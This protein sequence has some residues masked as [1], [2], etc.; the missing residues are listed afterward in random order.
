MNDDKVIIFGKNP[1]FEYIEKKPGRITK[2]FIKEDASS[3]LFKDIKARLHSTD[4]QLSAVPLAKLN[5]IA[6]KNAHHQGLIAEISPVPYLILEDWLEQINDK[7][8]IFLVIVDSIQDPHN[9]GAIIRTAVASG[10]TALMMGTRD[11][12]GINGT[13]IKT[14]SGLAEDIP[15][16]RVTNLNQGI[17][18]VK[19]ASF[20]LI[21]TQMQ[22]KLQFTDWEPSD[23]SALIIGSEGFGM[24]KS[25]E[26]LCDSVYSIPM[27]NKVE[28]LNA[29]VSAALMM[30]EWRRKQKN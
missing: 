8:N 11:Q 10:A 1:V 24:R 16:I 14:S 22:S 12:V 15:I 25:V 23:R 17:R 2:I 13:V 19:E 30:Y 6:G 27:N 26:A 18:K 21:G 20:E 4:V 28:S 7:E 29:S 5:K 9:F 3:E